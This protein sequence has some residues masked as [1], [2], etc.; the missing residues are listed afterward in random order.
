MRN[1][2]HTVL[3]VDDEPDVVSSVKDL[4]R[5]EYRVLGATRPEEGLKLA[6]QEQVD[7]VMTDQRMPEMSGVELL[8]RVRDRHP[9]ATRLLFT[10]YA[11]LRAVVDAI[12]QGNVYR[13]IT[14]PWDP[15]ELLTII[16]EACEHHDLLV[17]R[18]RLLEEVTKKNQALEQA[19][20][21]LQRADQLKSAFIQ[22]ASHELRTP[23]T[24][25]SGIAHLAALQPGVNDELAELLRRIQQA[26][27]RMQ[28]LI[29]QIVTMLSMQQFERRPSMTAH[30]I[31]RLI[32]RAADDV[33]PFIKTR[34]QVLVVDVPEDLGQLML[35]GE[36]IR[37]A[38]NHILLNAV[39]FT[40]DGGTIRVGARRE[41]AGEAAGGAGPAE[42][43]GGA[44]SVRIWVSDTGIGIEPQ[45]MARVF[46]RFFTSFDVS[47][48]SSGHFEYG[49]KGLGLGLSVVKA[50][51]EMHG[52]TVAVASE[53]GQGTTFTITL[54]AAPPAS[55]GNNQTAPGAGAG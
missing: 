17:D 11:D 50:F 44:A 27:G 21:E 13:Y 25:L 12:N 15:D 41:G 29:N 14:K 19:N 38:V 2:R 54:P 22:V 55:G 52:G 33:R 4:L 7:V 28:H 51:V 45:S 35:D 3:V 32:V 42:V 16:R 36:K 23:L 31:S 37:D 8:E 40:P 9:D 46:D 10:G 47:H 53:H 26:G 20:A 49:K 6:E 39:K 18:K 24:I 34:N 30:D 1:R 43:A 5:L 48:H